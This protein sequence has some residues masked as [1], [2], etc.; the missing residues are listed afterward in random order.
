MGANSRNRSRASRLCPISSPVLARVLTSNL[1][2]FYPV[3]LM[4]PADRDQLRPA[5][6]SSGRSDQL[7]SAESVAQS[8]QDRVCPDNG[9]AR[10]T[11]DFA[12]IEFLGT[13]RFESCPVSS[14]FDT[15]LLSRRRASFLTPNS[16]AGSA[17]RD[18]VLAEPL[19]PRASNDPRLGVEPTLTA[20]T[21]GG[22]IDREP[23][24]S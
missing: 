12:R 14:A 10:Q 16:P 13:T 7:R 3:S 19:E 6:L 9:V 8:A 24:L 17:G 22:L 11:V 23:N 18:P 4:R 21:V 5:R 1:R 2:V 20:P 15:A